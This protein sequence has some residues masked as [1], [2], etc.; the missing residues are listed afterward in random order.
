MTV[1]SK[2]GS[3]ALSTIGD[4][5]HPPEST[6][7]ADNCHALPLRD[8]PCLSDVADQLANLYQIPRVSSC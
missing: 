7:S 6:D 4:E 5:L 3:D 2:F 8:D 1:A